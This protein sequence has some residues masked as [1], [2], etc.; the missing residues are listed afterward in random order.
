MD[1]FIRR[2][3]IVWGPDGQAVCALEDRG[4][5]MIDNARLIA[6]A[7]EMLEALQVIYSMRGS[8]DAAYSERVSAFALAAI[9]KATGAA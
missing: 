9:A 2:T 3:Y 5:E 6:A 7:P 1:Q 4:G 8:T